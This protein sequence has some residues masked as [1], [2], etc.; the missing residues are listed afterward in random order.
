MLTQSAMSGA[1]GTILVLF[2]TLIPQ[3]ISEGL[4][5][6]TRFPAPLTSLVCAAGLTSGQF[7]LTLWSV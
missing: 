7:G 5:L 1:Q 3:V 6:K 2:I 4:Y